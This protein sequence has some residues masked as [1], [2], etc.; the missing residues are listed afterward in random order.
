MCH[1]TSLIWSVPNVRTCTFWWFY[2]LFFNIQCYAK[3]W[4][5]QVF[6]FENFHTD[7]VGFWWPWS[8]S[9]V[10]H[11]GPYFRLTSR[12]SGQKRTHLWWSYKILHTI[13]DR[14]FQLLAFLNKLIGVLGFL[15]FFFS[16]R[17]IMHA[18][19]K[20]QKF[21]YI[22]LVAT[23]YV[24]TLTIPSAVAVYWAFGD[25]LLDHSN[26]FSL[27]PQTGFR[28]AAV[29][30]M[31]IHQV[32]IFFLPLPNF[33]CPYNLTSCSNWLYISYCPVCCSTLHLD[34]LAHPCILCGRRWWGCMIQRAYV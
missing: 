14:L 10:F 12:I 2:Y 15:S 19:W 32:S 7:L 22:Y 34:L 8:K 3:T 33:Y 6:E 30:L 31:L 24:F 27:L 16:S 17:E 25:Q 18:M 21:K 11:G 23:L 28:D 5:H 13:A 1:M 29:I 4:T 20:P 26:A 9:E